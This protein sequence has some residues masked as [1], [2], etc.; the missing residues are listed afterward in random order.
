MKCAKNADLDKY[1]YSGHGIG[2]DSCSEFSL[3]DSRVSKNVI[4]FGVDMSASV[5]IDNKGKDILIFCKGPTQGL[6]D[7]TLSAEA[8]YSMNFS[9]SNRKFLSLHNNWS[10]SFLFANAAKI[11]QFNAK[12]SEIK[13]HPLCLGNISGDFSASNMKKKTRIKWVCVR[14]FC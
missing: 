2:F 4:T 14:F 6:D 3:P 5:H 10:S 12:Y 11:Y 7:I 13:N 1:V 8:Q 9:R